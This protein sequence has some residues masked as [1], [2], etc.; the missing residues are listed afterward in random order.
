MNKILLSTALFGVFCANLH[1]SNFI[2]IYQGLT[3]ECCHKWS[4]YL[5]ENG[6]ETK[7]IYL[8][9]EAFIQKKYDEKVP[10]ELASCH[11]ALIDGYVVEG[12]VPAGEIRI[13]LN[14]KPSDIIGIAVPAMPL[15]SPGMEVGAEPEIYDVIAIKKDGTTKVIATY[16]GKEKIK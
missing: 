10:L 16:K 1:A 5:R 2:E 4:A 6:F 12:H 15:E 13:I 8:D 7:H 11:T 3:C 9:D 14:Q